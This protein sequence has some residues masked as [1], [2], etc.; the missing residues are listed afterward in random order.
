MPLKPMIAVALALLS[1]CASAP[2]TKS[3]LRARPDELPRHASIDNV[4]FVEQTDNYCGPASMAMI[5]AWAGRPASLEQL[6]SEMYTPGKKGTLQV[7][8]LTAAR[9]HGL[10]ALPV[11]NLKDILQEIAVGNP[12]LVFQNLAFSWYRQWHYAVAIGYDLDNETILLHSGHSA[13]VSMAL[14]RFERTFNLG[15]DWAIA[16]LPPERLSGTADEF[17]H[18]QAVAALEQVGENRAA[19]VAYGRILKKWPNSLGALLGQGN[20]RFA[21]RDFTGALQALRAATRLN[22]AMSAAWHNLAFVYQALKKTAKAKAAARRAL[23]LVEARHST[24]YR[25]SLDPIL[26]P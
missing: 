22:S 20:A 8:I 18:L 11:N 1:G 10:L 13:S 5:L 26:S 7:D 17:S 23:Q 6:G 15:G 25:E 16:L 21:L 24:E 9:R 3:V 19:E 4:P 14:P 12:V 2:Q